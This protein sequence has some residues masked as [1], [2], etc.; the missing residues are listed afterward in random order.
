MTEKPLRRPDIVARILPDGYVLLEVTGTDWVHQLTPLGGIIWEF[1]DG[2]NSAADIVSR[3]GELDDLGPMP[4]LKEH[5]IRLLND[6]QNAKLL[7]TTSGGWR[8][9]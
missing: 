6:F 7:A 9:V 2:K 4:D 1:C 5:V 8:E 3:V